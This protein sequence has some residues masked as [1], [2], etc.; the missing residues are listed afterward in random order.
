MMINKTKHT[1]RAFLKQSFAATVVAI[2]TKAQQGFIPRIGVCT[3][4]RNASI[5]KEAG[6]DY[7]EESVRRFLVP[8]KSEEEFEINLEAAFNCGLPVRACNSFLPG[9]LKSTGP[10]ADHEGVIEYAATAFRRAQRA[11]IR[12]IVFGSS[13]SRSIPE[14]FNRKRAEDQFVTLLKQMG[15][16]AAPHGIVV[17]IEPLQVSET[18]FINTVP[19]GA[20]IV[21]RVNHPN[22]RLL[23]DI[24]HMLRMEEP[25]DHIRQA[26]DL[27]C[28]LHIAEKARRTPP[29][30]EG[31]D[32]R[33]YLHALIETGY[34]GCI[35]I[36]CGWEEMSSQLPAAVQTLHDQMRT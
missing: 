7:I 1:R 26:G 10:D 9:S 12:M 17:A 8:E 22:V 19:E 23:A 20:E 13:G 28:H 25:P 3:S 21:L 18:N 33:P 34:T 35:S 29:G 36:E 4:I 14:R 27:I 5:L 24:F 6:V 32:F 16:L 2:G 15:P 11:G 31:D 30:V